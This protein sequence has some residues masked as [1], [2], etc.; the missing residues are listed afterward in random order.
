MKAKIILPACL[1]V[2]AALRSQA[3]QY[4]EAALDSLAA[5]TDHSY[6]KF[7]ATGYTSVTLEFEGDE[8][9]NFGDLG[10]SP[11]LLWRPSKNILF[12]AEPEFEL[13]GS[14]LGIELEYA[15]MSFVVNRYATL[16]VGK[17]LTQFGIFQDRLHPA[18]INKL[19]TVPL[20]FSHDGVG[21]DS[22]V[23]VCFNGGA[24]IG[25]SKINYALYVSN[26]PSLD[27]G[28]EEPHE[29]GMLNYG[30][31]A[32]N[33]KN[34]AVGGR[35]GILPISNSSL[36]LGGSA[37]FAKVGAAGSEFED[38]R[39]AMFAADLTYINQLDFIKG[40]LDLK[41]QWNIVKVDDADYVD[42]ENPANTYTYDNRRDT[43]FAQFAYRPTLMRNDVLKN[44]E[45][46]FRYSNLD[47]PDGAHESEDVKQWAVGL[48]YWL[49]WRSVVKLAYQSE[50]EVNAFF[51]Q[52]AISF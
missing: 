10:F 18:W 21:P 34:K 48:N 50:G 42:P 2:L 23:G 27:T 31:T 14:E 22:E 9:V 33:N 38:V 3:Q 51:V 24:P 11:I 41:A 29:A 7:L 36:E 15:N 46:V 12:E 6:G 25:P 40:F 30:S 35:L 32:D 13:E 52:S 4:N 43:W 28:E 5:T 39:T 26:G 49:N 44:V 19:P 37:Q 47:L 1:L 17:F 16:M 20:G 8:A 45:V